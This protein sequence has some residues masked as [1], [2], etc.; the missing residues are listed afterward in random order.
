M[1]PFPSRRGRFAALPLII[2]FALLAAAPVCA[3]QSTPADP[4]TATAIEAK[5]LV[6]ASRH[7]IVTANPLASEA[8][9]EILR[10]G[11]TALDAAIAAQMVLNLVEPQSSG[12]GGGAFLLHWDGA[13]VTAF[14]GRERAPAAAK[15]DRFLGPDG[16]PMNF[17]EAVKS[18]RSV[19]VPGLLRMLEMAHARHGGLPWADLFAPA[20][21]LADK[22]FPV[23]PRLSKLL[24]WAGPDSFSAQARALY[25]DA[26]GKPRPAGYVLSNPGFAATLRRV[27]A[28]GAKA[29]HEGAL[30]QSIV[31]AVNA[32]PRTLGDMTAG[33]LAAYR[34]IER[35]PLCVPYRDWKVCGMGPPSSGGTTVAATLQMLEASDLGGEPLAPQDIHLIAEAEKLAYADRDRYVADP[36]FAPVPE[37]LNDGGYL[38]ERALLISPDAAAAKALPGKPPGVREGA[39][40]RD[41]TRESGGTSHVSVVDGAGRAVSL[42]TTIESGFGSGIMVGGFL[43]NNELTDFSFRPQAADG[44]PVANRV[45]GGKRP[46]SSMAPTLVFDRDGKLRMITGSPGGSRIILYVV[47]SLVAHL[48]W[49][50]DAQGSAALANFGSR[51]GPLEV[52]TGLPAAI[53]EALRARGH[54]VREL[55]MTSGTHNIV[56]TG[57]G[58]EGGADPRREGAAMGD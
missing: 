13:E 32:A 4:E 47:K 39:F 55:P 33:D 36:D 49:G 46:R 14:D 6:R 20:I 43:L 56:V 17:R 27:A 9:R 41:A 48:H 31:E 3:Q 34:A 45:E 26:G 52:E 11:G 18:G 21:A 40:G 44:R 22:G 10:G 50:L 16:K 53:V 58:L 54:T 19:G 42:T 51:N 25:F 35:R 7:M 23:S 1:N 2:C 8:G 29:L 24:E 5:T 12:I 28:E 38:R 37:G 30:A 15:P 57:Q